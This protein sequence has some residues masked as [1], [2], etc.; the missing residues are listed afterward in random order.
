MLHGE[1]IMN[2]KGEQGGKILAA[3]EEY[4]L[5][6]DLRK[7]LGFTVIVDAAISAMSGANYG[8]SANIVG[9]TLAAGLFV[10]GSFTQLT[11]AASPATGIIQVHYSDEG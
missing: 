6:S 10:A 5:S 3:S 9:P 7:A 11:V 4:L 2:Q 8:G 1:N